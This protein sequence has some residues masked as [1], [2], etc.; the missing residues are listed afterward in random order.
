MRSLNK[1]V[2]LILS[3]FFVV[4]FFNGDWES[5]TRDF[6]DKPAPQQENFTPYAEKTIGGF[7]FVFIPGGTFI[8]GTATG[9]N[10][11]GPPHNVYISGFWL[12]KYETTQSQWIDLMGENPSA[13]K[14]GGKYPVEN[15]S[16]YECIDFIFKF[17]E[18]FQV[19]TRFPT[20][21]EWE[22]ACRGGTTT[23]YFWG[24]D[25]SKA[26]EYA[27]FGDVSY[28]GDDARTTQNDGFEL[29]APVGNF[30]AN[31]YGLY[32]MI[33]NVE[34]WTVDSHDNFYYERS[35]AKNPVNLDISLRKM[36]RGGSYHQGLTV[37]D[38]ANR[39]FLFP[40]KGLKNTGFRL[41]LIEKGITAEI[42]YL[43]NTDLEKQ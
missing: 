6:N 2:R 41:L 8:M 4:V 25:I 20:E 15:I 18:K 40:E 42:E 30:K 5:C 22:Y 12:S 39:M 36:I 7:D 23:K 38:C 28:S 16:W 26:F 13:N 32:D 27:N 37:L 17:N 3:I 19:E 14:L 29:T 35:P 31:G 34:E 24:S 21:A 43:K 11:E 1:S 10:I 9:S 33:G